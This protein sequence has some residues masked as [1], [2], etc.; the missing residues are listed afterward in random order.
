MFIE[1]YT[2]DFPN[3]FPSLKY[4]S[5]SKNELT[6]ECN[7]LTEFLEEVYYYMGRTLYD[8]SGKKAREKPDKYYFSKDP[9]V[10]TPFYK[11]KTYGIGA[12]IT[13]DP[14]PVARDENNSITFKKL[15]KKDPDF[16]AQ[17]ARFYNKN[18]RSLKGFEVTDSGFVENVENKKGDSKLFLNEPYV[19]ITRLEPLTNQHVEKGEYTCYLT[20]EK[21]KKLVDTQNTSP[22]IKGLN[23]FNSKLSPSSQKV[24]WKAMYLS[25][26]SPKLGL[27]CY[28]SGLDSLVCFFY[29]SDSLVNLNKLY[30]INRSFYK[31]FEQ[32]IE[33]N[34]MSNFNVFNFNSEKK[35]DERLIN[36]RDYSWSNEL[37][38][39]L[40]YTIYQ[41]LLYDSGKKNLDVSSFF[42]LGIA[43]TPISLVSFKADKFSGTNRPNEF[44][45]FNRFKFLISFIISAEQQGVNFSQVLRSLKFIK[46]SQRS[47]GN[48]F[49]LERMIRN[50]I[51][52]KIITGKSILPEIENLF[53]NCFTYILSGDY[54]GYK[55]YNQLTS[56]LRLYEL[57]INKKMT[58]ET[59][60][61]AF[62]LGTS[63]GIAVT[64]ND[65]K[66][67]RKYIIGL[68]KARTIPQFNDAIIRLMNRYS[69]LKV[70]G[71]LFKEMLNEEDF[72]LIKQ[73]AV[74][75]ALNVINLKL[76]P[77][78]NNE[79]DK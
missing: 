54:V 6:I 25:R 58:K 7:K 31:D 75:G 8:T 20:S 2:I 45:Y 32:I 64:Q 76:K 24:S 72:I 12:L 73:F 59:Q 79:N 26:F 1:K 77:I 19:K 3:S 34:Y 69:G 55:D 10:A 16:A 74:I 48:K 71:E 33:A 46:K 70:S 40:V 47:S 13:N 57:L 29:D 43:K 61:K 22:F 18:N 51:L 9:F 5:P 44:E 38:F 67:S 42:D 62:K 52:G 17:I 56:F 60:E 30:Q 41:Q 27:Y 4:S 15:S 68:N 11:M 49:K 53:Y 65:V 21:V 63:I 78:K 23:N 35:G 36:N 50:R 28:T 14:V 37:K 66:S 39:V